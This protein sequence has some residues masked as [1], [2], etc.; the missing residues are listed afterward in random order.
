MENLYQANRFLTLSTTIK[1]FLNL[2]NC[3]YR[4]ILGILLFAG[5]LSAFAEGSKDLY[6]TGLG[7]RAFLQSR[8]I[9]ATPATY[10]LFPTPGTMKVYVISGEKLYLGSSAQGYDAGQIK[11][12]KP[13]GIAVTPS[14]I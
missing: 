3:C 4:L 5:S 6:K 9:G 8:A 1:K 12:R 11:V 13:S 14:T 10:D 2:R 7:K